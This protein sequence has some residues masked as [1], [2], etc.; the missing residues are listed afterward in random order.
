MT[1]AQQTTPPAAVGADPAISVRDL[2]QSYGDFEAVRGISFDVAPGELFAL[3]GTNGAGK[4]TTIE[5]LEGFRRPTG[6]SVRVFGTDPY[7]QPAELRERMDG[8]LQHS[9]VFG[10]L[11]VAE[12]VDLSRDLAADPRDR[13]EVLE[14]VDLA[15]KAK[16]AVRQLSGGQR[17]RLD[18]GLAVL[19]RPEVLFLDEPTTGMDPEARRETWKIIKGLVADGVAILLTTHY[20]EE[21]ERL[22]DRLAIMHRGEVKVEGVLDDV[23]VGWGD[24]IG[25]RLPGRIRSEELPELPGA[26]VAVGVREGDPWVVYTV[27][28][29]DT[30]RRAHHAMGPLLSWADQHETTLERLELRSASLED[31]FLGIVDEGAA[32]LATA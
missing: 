18:L 24:R 2:R 22:A 14:L 10:E 29:A 4:T 1:T 12:T 6:G 15:D 27:N 5:T 16:V 25:F 9:G 23:L 28:G 26:T 32:D 3:L 21:A 17:R 11:T 19:S 8:V 13:A 20:L 30:A 31:V 7:G